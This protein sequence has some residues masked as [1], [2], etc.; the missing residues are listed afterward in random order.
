MNPKTFFDLFGEDGMQGTKSPPTKVIVDK[1]K[2]YGLPGE[3]KPSP[4]ELE[5]LLVWGEV[6]KAIEYAKQNRVR[7]SPLDYLV[8]KVEQWCSGTRQDQQSVTETLFR[9]T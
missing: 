2:E 9:E 6:E 4:E 3:I 5:Y 7:V 8:N 1:T